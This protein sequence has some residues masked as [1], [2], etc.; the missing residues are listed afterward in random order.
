MAGSVEDELHLG[1]RPGAFARLVGYRELRVNRRSISAS[2]LSPARP[3]R[4]ARGGSGPTT[5]RTVRPEGSV[6]PATARDRWRR[7]CHG[8]AFLDLRVERGHLDR[9]PTG[10]TSPAGPHRA[11]ARGVAL[12]HQHVNAAGLPAVLADAVAVAIDQ[13]EAVEQR[14]RASR[15]KGRG[16]TSEACH[17]RLPGVMMLVTG[18]ALP[19][20]T[21]SMNSSRS[22]ACATAS[23]RARSR[24]HAAIGVS[25][26]R[27]A[28]G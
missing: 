2:H 18:S 22:T 6:S 13:V 27:R 9:R 20:N 24:S 10:T 26:A 12:L 1:V 14:T 21:G 4:G 5:A 17:A 11:L 23:R 25:P 15:E 19:W 8:Q 7:R 16:W 28:A 3:V